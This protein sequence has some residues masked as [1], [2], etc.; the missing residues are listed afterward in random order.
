MKIGMDSPTIT[1]RQNVVRRLDKL[2]RRLELQAFGRVKHGEVPPEGRGDD[3]CR[4]S[5]R[6]R[7]GAAKHGQ[8]IPEDS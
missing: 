3:P 4:R 8:E 1:I 2:A 6:H 5:P 7:L